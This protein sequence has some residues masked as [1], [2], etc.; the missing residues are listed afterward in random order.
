[1]IIIQHGNKAKDANWWE[2]TDIRCNG[3]ECIFQIERKDIHSITI[4]HPRVV[5]PPVEKNVLLDC[6]DCGRRILIRK[7]GQQTAPLFPKSDYNNIFE[8]IFG[9]DGY[10][11]NVFSKLK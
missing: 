10:F 2:R 11:P 1:M 8:E 4:D 6:P 5:E 7:P 9:K 3:C